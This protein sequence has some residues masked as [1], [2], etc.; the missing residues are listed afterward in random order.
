MKAL[1]RKLWREL[2]QMKGQAIAIVLV[3]VSGVAIHVMF[4]ATLDALRQTRARYYQEY[5]FADVFAALK[6]AP[7]SLRARIAAIPGV[8]EVETRVVAAVNLEVAGF[9]EPITG[10]LISIPDNRESR[11]NRLYLRQ[12]RLTAA[13]RD[14][15]AVA[16]EAF[17]KAHRLEPG[18]RL[19]VVINGRRQTLTIVGTALSPE[20]IQQLRPGSMFPDYQRYGVLWMGR[21]S[22]CF[23]SGQKT[24]AARWC[25]AAWGGRALC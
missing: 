21:R 18:A 12:G 11:L 4:G 14:D 24:Q 13:D 6:R 20:Y 8:V 2:W 9:A 5:R 25:S 7:E 15:E 3:I 23:P 19:R 1:D 16:S 10:R 17:A 22:C